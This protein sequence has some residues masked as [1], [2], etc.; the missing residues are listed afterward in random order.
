MNATI[1]GRLDRLKVLTDLGLKKGTVYFRGLAL[2]FDGDPSISGNIQFTH[3][4]LTSILR[5][6]GIAYR[7]TSKKLKEA[8]LAGNLRLS[9]KSI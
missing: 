3:G 2:P 7:P 4:D 6:F 1:N 8:K 5:T 9:G